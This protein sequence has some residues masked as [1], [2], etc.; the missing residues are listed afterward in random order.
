MIGDRVFVGKVHMLVNNQHSLILTADCRTGKYC[1][2]QVATYEGTPSFAPRG[3][4]RNP[5]KMVRGRRTVPP[6]CSKLA[7]P[8]ARMC[9]RI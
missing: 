2:V 8:V 5:K 1:T 4:A 6:A 7:V 3:T 9:G